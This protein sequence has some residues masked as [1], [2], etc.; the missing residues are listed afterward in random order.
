MR[1]LHPQPPRSPPAGIGLKVR[2]RRCGRDCEEY[3]AERRT[4]PGDD[5]S[6]AAGGNS[7]Y[8]YQSQQDVTCPLQMVCTFFACR[9]VQT[10]T[11]IRHACRIQP[12]FDRLP[13]GQKV[14]QRDGKIFVVGIGPGNR[15]DM[16]AR[17]VAALEQSDIIAGYTVYVDLVRSQNAEPVN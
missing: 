5:P 2:R 16:T 14:A 12:F 9:V 11:E 15:L 4:G 17:A 1:L 10:D 3:R 6:R 7:G 13:R 8:V